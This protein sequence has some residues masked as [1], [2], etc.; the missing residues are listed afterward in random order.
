MANTIRNFGPVLPAQQRGAV[1]AITMIMLMTMTVV[2]IA[3]LSNTRLQENMA[4]NLQEQVR[5]MQAADSGAMQ[6][7]SNAKRAEYNPSVNAFD[8]AK[9]NNSRE[10]TYTLYNGGGTEVNGRSVEGLARYRSLGKGKVGVQPEAISSDDTP[11]H[12]FVWQS[13]AKTIST[14]AAG[15]VY[16][17][18]M[19]E[20]AGSEYFL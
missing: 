7:W 17:G 3:A 2:G 12:F 4:G 14:K 6:A 8:C 13:R 20:G 5:V 16:V 11:A 9:H 10:F 18:V 15:A 1:L 19:I